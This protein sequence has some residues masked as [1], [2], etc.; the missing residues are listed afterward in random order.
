MNCRFMSYIW[1][2]EHLGEFY[3]VPPFLIRILAVTNTAVQ[4]CETIE[5]LTE[6]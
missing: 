5:I 4:M 2:T 1:K 3:I 6:K